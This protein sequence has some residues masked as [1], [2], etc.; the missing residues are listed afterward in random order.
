MGAMIAVIK[1]KVTIVALYDSMS[2]TC[3]AKAGM[4]SC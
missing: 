1:M 4:P 3:K 2:I